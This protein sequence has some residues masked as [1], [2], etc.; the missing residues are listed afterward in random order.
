MKINSDFTLAALFLALS[1][2]A[3]AVKK[4]SRSAR[5]PFPDRGFWVTETG[6]DRKSTIV[7]Y[8]ANSN[9]LVSETTEPELLDVRKLSVRKYLNHKLKTEL[10]KDTTQY[11]NPILY[12]RN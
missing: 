1:L 6:K 8:Y 2:H 9:R 7:K 11:T 4:A 12:E 5:Q 3:N 10:E